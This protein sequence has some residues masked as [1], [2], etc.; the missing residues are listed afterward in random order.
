MNSQENLFQSFQKV[1]KGEL[2]PED[3]FSTLNPQDLSKIIY[4]YFSD[5]NNCAFAAGEGILEGDVSRLTDPARHN[6]HLL[7]ND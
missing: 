3:V 7:S 1:A 2:T 4:P 5:T 6:S